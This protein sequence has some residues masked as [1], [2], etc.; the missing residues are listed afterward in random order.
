MIDPVSDGL[1]L[2][3]MLGMGLVIFAVLS[4]VKKAHRNRDWE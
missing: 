1:A 4:A 3:L 2:L